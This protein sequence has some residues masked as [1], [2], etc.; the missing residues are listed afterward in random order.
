ME[1]KSFADSKLIIIISGIFILFGL[2]LTT[3]YDYLLFHSI[4]E[5]FIIVVACGIFII[6]WNSR[7]L[8]DNNYLLFIGVAYLFIA[9]LELIH[10]LGYAGMD[11]F[12]GYGA[13]LPTQLWIAARYMESFSLLIAP[14]FFGRRLKL[15]ILFIV[16]GSVTCL[17]FLS[18]FL[19]NIFP[20]CFV[21]GTGL[22]SFK[23]I[24]EYIISLI[25][26]GSIALLFQKQK[27]FE[28]GVY[29][30]LIASI[31]LSIAAELAFTFYIHV[32]GFS[33]LIGHYF[34]V[35]SFYFIYKAIIE[36]GLVK[37]HA[38]LF[39]NL[40]QSEE[41]LRKSERK[42]KLLY[43]RAPLS[44]QSLAE[45]GLLVDVN[46]TWLDTLGY[47]RDEVLGKSFVDFLHSDWK[48]QFK[49]KFSL[50]KSVGE[51]LG[52]EY[53]IVK[54]DG[55]TIFVSFTGKIGTDKKEDFHQTHW[56]FTDI[57]ER[58]QLEK[59]LQE[60]EEKY[61]SMMESMEDEAYICSSDLRIEYMNPAT[62]SRVGHDAAGELCH[63][64]IYGLDKE[65]SW[66]MLD[67]VL[68]GENVQYELLNPNN[69]RYYSISSSPIRHTDGSISKLTAC[70]DITDVK[71]ME[72]QLQQTHK[73]QAIATLAGGMAHQFNN[74]LSPVSVNLDM[75]DLDSGKDERITKYTAPIKESV[76][77]LADLTSQLLAYARGGKYSPHAIS[78][79]DFVRINLPVIEASIKPETSIE[80]DLPEGIL[81]IEADP[82][83]I[84]MVLSAVLENASES[85]EGEGHIR[86]IIE[87]EEINEEFARKHADL[88]VGPYVCIRIEDNGKGM[89]EETRRRIFE[90]FFTTK[91]QGRGLGLAAA[92]G[93]IKNHD[94][95]ITIDS[96]PTKGT[97]ARIYLPA[98]EDTDAGSL[99]IP[100]TQI[101]REKP[102]K[103]WS[104][105]PRG[106]GTIL[107]IEDEELVMYAAKMV[108]EKLDY[109]VLEARTGKEAVDIVKTYE[110]DIDLAILDMKLPD[111]GG[112]KVYPSIKEARPDM[113][114]IICSGYALDESIRGILNRGA[115]GFI[116]K[117]FALATLADKLKEVLD[118]K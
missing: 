62:V 45:N 92:Y 20:A 94:G 55:S 37:P 63:K 57:T 31:M 40:K 79:N 54:K 103:L 24:S 34:T 82:T 76:H 33:N 112:E 16:Y 23:K 2:Y 64:A 78:L 104:E 56:I 32:Y 11:I 61:R 86:I 81:A 60:S 30:L 44:Y 113:K 93:I 91:F 77:R 17:I 71:G 15:N 42:F 83:Q 65:C 70:R 10:T 68:K 75:L 67:K 69:N 101:E 53:E 50:C 27:N 13:N 84:Q 1:T 59:T 105:I 96:E 98:I 36:T 109:Q 89:D 73:L 108:L 25:Y 118:E 7:R 114:V 106:T 117:P 107:V 52:V 95:L 35:I 90:P 6:A 99:D 5:V 58:K 39:R 49:E 22:T 115:Q 48:G 74:A 28:V 14:F 47:T 80:T 110:G 111:I 12:K 100:A 85:I 97:T 41:S 102:F 19:W 29:R 8:L 72:L 66:C 38:L 43:D 26:I 46:Q 87:N 21:E 51:A 88:K 4:A 9:V 3:L 116:E 18:I